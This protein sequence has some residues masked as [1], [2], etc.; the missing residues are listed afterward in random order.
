MKHHGIRQL[1]RRA[2]LAVCLLA[3]TLSSR[4]SVSAQGETKA[5]T[6][7]PA[8]AA[9]AK[10][11][12]ISAVGQKWT[13]DFDGM[14]KR[15]RIRILTPY[16]RTHYFIDKGVQRGLVY[17][18][19]VRLEAQINTTLK[20]TPATKI[21][22]VF[23]PTSRDDLQRAL[24]EGEGDIVAANVTVSPELAK[25]ADFATPAKTGVQE[26]VVTGP[27]ASVLRT[28]DDLGGKEVYVREK[29][30]QFQSLMALNAKLKQQGKAAVVVKTLPL[31]LEDEDIL[32]M[33][34]AGLLKATVVDDF[35]GQFWK[36]VLPNLTLY[37]GLSVRDDG[38][39]AWAVRKDSP[40]LLAVLNP[41]FVA[42]KQGTLFGNGILQKYPQEREV[43][44]KR[45]LRR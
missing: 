35:M 5:P 10:T 29:S 25:V 9:P 1:R 15:R 12:A 42:N 22:V 34:N 6:T 31:S 38:L 28:L 13:G 14:V 30:I 4:S 16:S 27:G 2:I 23:R 17:D 19:G 32:E 7:P 20:T 37:P 45:D 44:E 33:V 11:S 39:V 21:A 24:V 18:A 40:K 43:R 8:T 3:S 36:Q 26:I 41:F